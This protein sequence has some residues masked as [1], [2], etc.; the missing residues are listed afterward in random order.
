[1]GWRTFLRKLN[2]TGL[3]QLASF[4]QK[5]PF[6]LFNEGLKFPC[7]F[8][9]YL[10]THREDHELG[11]KSHLQHEQASKA[12]HVNNAECKHQKE[13]LLIALHSVCGGRNKNDAIIQNELK[14]IEH[15]EDARMR[16]YSG[17]AE[18]RLFCVWKQS[19][20]HICNSEKVKKSN[21]IWLSSDCLKMMFCISRKRPTEQMLKQKQVRNIA[22]EEIFSPVTSQIVS[23]VCIYMQERT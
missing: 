19:D 14:L 17:Q 15:V 10:F 18:G 13:V 16:I 4:F 2:F 1:M 5:L 8:W 22:G 23:S 3:N 21:Q 12:I 20:R 9:A 7:V 11:M 6:Q